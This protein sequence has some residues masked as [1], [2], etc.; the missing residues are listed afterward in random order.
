M[1]PRS[2]ACARSA[3][4]IAPR[5]PATTSILAIRRVLAAAHVAMD[6]VM[7]LDRQE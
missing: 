5:P 7:D 6:G 2:S 4:P 1:A 3:V